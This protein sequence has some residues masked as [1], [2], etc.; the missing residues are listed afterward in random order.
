M[1]SEK[2]EPAS[3]Q[4]LR[5]LRQLG[6]EVVDRLTGHAATVLIND[7]VTKL[8]LGRGERLPEITTPAI[9]KETP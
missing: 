2:Y 9:T 6:V 8:R 4:Q 7:A 3:P 1:K 5:R